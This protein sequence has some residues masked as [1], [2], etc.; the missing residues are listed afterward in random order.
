[1]RTDD[2][3][4]ASVGVEGFGGGSYFVLISSEY[5]LGV[6]IL[7]D[8]VGHVGSRVVGWRRREV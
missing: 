7:F 2:C 1:M 5:S 6:A 4:D 8:E 3:V